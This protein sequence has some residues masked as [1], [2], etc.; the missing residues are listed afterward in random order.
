MIDSAYTSIT[1]ENSLQESLLPASDDIEDIIPKSYHPIDETNEDVEYTTNNSRLQ[2]TK[3]EFL[4]FLSNIITA[5]FLLLPVYFTKQFFDSRDHT[6]F[7]L[8]ALSSI[9]VTIT[10]YLSLHELSNH[11]TY[12]YMPSAQKYVL[13]ILA[14][15]PLYSVQSWLSLWPGEMLRISTLYLEPFRDLYETYAI[16]SFLYYLEALAG[17]EEE[18]IGMLRRKDNSYGSH[19]LFPFCFLCRE[20]EMG[21][22]FLLRC[23][24]GVLLFIILKLISVA[25]MIVLKPLGLYGGEG[26]GNAIDLTQVYVYVALIL[27]ASMTW[28]LYCL[29]MLYNAIKVE[30]KEWN[31]IGKFL[32]IKGL[33]FFT[34]WQGFV[35]TVVQHYGGLSFGQS[36]SVD[37]KYVRQKLQALIICVEM[38]GFAIAH[39]YAFTF[40]EYYP[41]RMMGRDS[42]DN[43]KDN[44]LDSESNLDNLVETDYIGD[45]GD[46][47]SATAATVAR[48]MSA[49]SAFWSF[50]PN[51]GI[52]DMKRL[53][54]GVIH[55]ANDKK[56][57]FFDNVLVEMSHAQDL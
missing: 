19:R 44:L 9:F 28:A 6:Q 45:G 5:L 2:C 14:L 52:K 39:R 56:E 23:K 38:L 43:N 17:G 31:L 18:L 3:A 33:V 51:E 4:H 50:I 24:H 13:R 15:V 26:G 30:L 10:L 35:I 40:R 25:I 49:S 22:E 7:R 53:S 54:R 42:N 11:L 1:T 32:C 8:V 47:A 41:E 20:W 57:H 12:M 48:P 16:A 55:A 27:S 29:A 36:D 37:K 21:A 34:F 46:N